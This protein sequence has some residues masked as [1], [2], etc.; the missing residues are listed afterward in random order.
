MSVPNSPVSTFSPARTLSHRM[1]RYCSRNAFCTI[2]A[3]FNVCM[4]LVC[5]TSP[6][7]NFDTI[8]SLSKPVSRRVF[9]KPI[10]PARKTF[11]VCNIQ[12]INTRVWLCYII[13]VILWWKSIFFSIVYYFTCSGQVSESFIKGMSFFPFSQSCF[14]PLTVNT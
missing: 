13:L 11:R 4:C 10:T 8:S 12:I 3:H 1:R 7:K 9:F 5:K 6:S 14:V 2:T